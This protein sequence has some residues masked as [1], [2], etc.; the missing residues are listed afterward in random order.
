MSG[1]FISYA[2]GDGFENITNINYIDLSNNGLVSFDP[3]QEL[4]SLW[5]LVLDSNNL[6]KIPALQG[7]VSSVELRDNLIS[8]VG[9]EYLKETN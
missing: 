8:F 7:T 3:V 9:G 6:T 1:N 5:T 4:L 2:C